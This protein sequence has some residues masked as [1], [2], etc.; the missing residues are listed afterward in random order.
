MIRKSDILIR[1]T[2]FSATSDAV[3]FKTNE[4]GPRITIGLNDI[5]E[6]LQLQKPRILRRMATTASK[7]VANNPRVPGSGESLN[8]ALPRPILP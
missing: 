8:C 1:N 7:P 2:S 6:P 5:M 3:P 4:T